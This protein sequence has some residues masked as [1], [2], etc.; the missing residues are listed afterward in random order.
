[1]RSGKLFYGT[2]SIPSNTAYSKLD[3][4][5]AGLSPD[6]PGPR[7]SQAL[8]PPSAPGALLNKATPL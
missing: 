8:N 1:M 4:V 7:P 3:R 5:S 2:N 6:R